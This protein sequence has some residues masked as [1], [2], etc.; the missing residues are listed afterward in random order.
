MN[1]CVNPLLY[2][3][4]CENFRVAF[5]KLRQ[6]DRCVNPLLYAFLSENFRVAFRKVMYCPPPYHDSGRPQPTKTTRTGN[7]N[8]CH[9]IV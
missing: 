8:S 3:F 7:G 4:L 5:R 9:D 2:A 1:S 6:L